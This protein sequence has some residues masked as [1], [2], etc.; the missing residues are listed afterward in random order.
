MNS[1]FHAVKA[2]FNVCVI[3]PDLWLT[4]V[5]SRTSTSYSS[6]IEINNH[7]YLITKGDGDLDVPIRQIRTIYNG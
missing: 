7:R 2:Y 6:P 4:C 5:S 3:A 1:K